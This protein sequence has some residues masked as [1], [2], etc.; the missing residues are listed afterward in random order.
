MHAVAGFI[1]RLAAYAVLLGIA[2]RLAQYWW[3]QRGLGDVIVLQG[4][5]DTAVAVLALAPIVLA[6]LGVGPLRP[7]A[8]FVAW[9]LVGAALAAP[10]VFARLAAG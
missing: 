9:F 7:L 8:V 2:A 3:D 1:V 6:L 10:F 5:H 4:V